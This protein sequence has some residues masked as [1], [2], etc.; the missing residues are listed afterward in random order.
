MVTVSCVSGLT[1]FSD[2][3]HLGDCYNPSPITD[4]ALEF[5]SDDKNSYSSA[6]GIH[7]RTYIAGR[8]QLFGANRLRHADVIIWSGNQRNCGCAAGCFVFR[9][10]CAVGSSM[11]RNI[12]S[13]QYY[14]H[15]HYSGSSYNRSRKNINL[16]ARFWLLFV[17]GVGNECRHDRERHGGN[18][19]FEDCRGC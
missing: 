12:C 11:D 6:R 14:F 17:C 8:S 9:G 2:G 5:D 16:R 7:H 13:G 19:K 4:L 3:F 10:K 1:I 15:I 18:C